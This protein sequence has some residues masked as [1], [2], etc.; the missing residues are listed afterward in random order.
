MKSD[1]LLRAAALAAFVVALATPRAPGQE[2]LAQAFG[3][4]ASDYFGWSIASGGPDLDGDGFAE[5]AVGA[6]L[7]NSSHG[8]GV[9]AAYVLSGRDFTTIHAI[10][11]SQG[12]VNPGLTL[13]WCGDLDGDGLADLAVGMPGLDLTT[14]DMG[15]V[16]IYSTGTWTL[17]RSFDGAS[18][19]EFF[20]S[21]LASLA[22]IDGDGVA[23]LIVGAGNE[24]HGVRTSGTV[25]VY[26]GASGT[27]L[28]N[29][30]ASGA[31]SLGGAVAD[32]GDV[33]GDGVNDIGA[34][35]PNTR[36]P[37]PNDLQAGAAFV[38]SGADGSQLLHWYGSA[39]H[40]YYYYGNRLGIGIG[41]AGDVDGDGRDD[42]WVSAED[43][44]HSA[45]AFVAI[46]SGAT[47][48]TIRTLAGADDQFA[49]TT[50]GDID[51]DGVADFALSGALFVGAP[52][53][54]S[55]AVMLLSGGDGRELW[56]GEDPDPVAYF[57]SAL[58]ATQDVNHDGQFEL[59]VGAAQDATVGNEAG[60]VD[61]LG[62]SDF[63]LDVQRTHF[64]KAG[65][66]LTLTA[67]KGPPGNLVGLFLTAVNGAPTFALLQL[68]T[69]DATGQAQWS[70]TVPNGFTGTSFALRSLAIGGTGKVVQSTDETIAIQ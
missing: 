25:Y 55:D 39:Y 37:G 35:A 60:R 29:L 8:S 61:L 63:W 57:G 51:G 50:V 54:V 24:Q 21:A 10:Y 17:L 64:P 31:E 1:S 68:T 59:A 67:L 70:S 28:L 41:A 47:G 49:A 62:S 69:F 12:D 52:R 40:Y 2:L 15:R 4:E 7:L 22:D 26:S 53:Y 19:D 44:L 36:Y 23:E 13:A 33:N 65:D 6:L 11:G 46:Y 58:A 42:V 38:F 9:G 56:R 43:G 5:I 3:E 20:G 27:V 32:V 16:E 18:S 48:A 30:T 45:P 34:G 14:R 66:A